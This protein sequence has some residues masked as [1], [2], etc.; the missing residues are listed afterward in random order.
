MMIYTSDVGKGRIFR[1]PLF[2]TALN[3]AFGSQDGGATVQDPI[4]GDWPT[5]DTLISRAS[6]LIA[7]HPDTSGPS[8]YRSDLEKYEVL[9]EKLNSNK[10][11]VTP[12][13]PASCPRR[14]YPRSRHC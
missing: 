12:S 9:L 1:F 13:N 8:S 2:P 7:A 10:A 14:F 11:A 6:A 4:M 3:V 5:V